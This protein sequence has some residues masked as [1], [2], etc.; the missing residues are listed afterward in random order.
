MMVSGSHTRVLRQV[1]YEV[2]Q[3]QDVVKTVEKVVYV[4]RPVYRKRP[5]R[6]HPSNSSSISIW[7]A[8]TMPGGTM[9]SLAA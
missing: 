6:S 3:M 2:I 5:V 8:A 9:L 4:K 1:P 7:V